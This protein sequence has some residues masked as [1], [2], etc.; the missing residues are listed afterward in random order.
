MSRIDPMLDQYSGDHLNPTNQLIHV[1]C[2]PAIVWSVSAMLWT[3]PVPAS[4]IVQAGA[5]YA[6]VAFLA[7]AWYWR[8]SRKLAV[9]LLLCFVAAGFL[10]RWI[11]DS[12]GMRTLLYAGIAVFVLAWIAQFIGHKIE[13]KRPSFL[14][15]LVYLLVGP[16]WTLNK[17]YRRVG[18]G[19]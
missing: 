1:I 14:T 11:V 4:G 5:W 6:F 12:W 17:L 7:F 3:I 8:Q 15:D 18:I 16:A 19:H 2:V 9:G 10:N 13:G